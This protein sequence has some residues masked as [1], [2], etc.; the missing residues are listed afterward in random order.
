MFLHSNKEILFSCNLKEI[1]NQIELVLG[2]L[3]L[4][5]VPWLSNKL[6]YLLSFLIIFDPQLWILS[7]LSAN[8]IGHSVSV[9]M[10]CLLI[11]AL[12]DN[13]YILE[14]T[15]HLIFTCLV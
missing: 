11:I 12:F 7:S 9:F 1:N 3:Y 2:W 13:M 14:S 6:V 8:V 4:W 15:Y 10:H 5:A